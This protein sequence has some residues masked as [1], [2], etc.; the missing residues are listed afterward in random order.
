M[1]GGDE[2]H[3]AHVCS[4]RVHLIDI[5]SRRDA[6]V[7]APKV[8][9]LELVCIDVRVLGVLEVYAPHPVAALSR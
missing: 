5:A 9:D 7:P 2:T 8:P 6:L 3:A 4:E 1:V